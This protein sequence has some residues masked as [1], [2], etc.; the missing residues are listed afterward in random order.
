[1][2]GVTVPAVETSCAA[3]AG[4]NEPADGQPSSPSLPPPRPP[5]SL[6]P[7]RPGGPAWSLL[8]AMARLFNVSSIVVRNWDDVVT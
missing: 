1:M 6:R 4:W 5:P 7:P 8:T 2:H 3:E